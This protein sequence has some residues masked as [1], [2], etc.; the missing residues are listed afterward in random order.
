M[1]KKRSNKKGVSEVIT[2]VLLLLLVLAAIAIIWTFLGPAIKRSVSRVSDECIILKLETTSC[3][4]NA[5]F[6]PTVRI[7]RGPGEV[8]LVGLNIVLEL[9]N[10]DTELRLV[11]TNLPKELEARVYGNLTALKDD[12]VNAK[13]AGKVI[14][15]NGEEITCNPTTLGV[16]CTLQ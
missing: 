16:P 8:E 4:Y 15:V 14:N 13:V 12:P 9:A 1:I 10:K 6:S 11:E 3:T 7:N 2:L 5:S